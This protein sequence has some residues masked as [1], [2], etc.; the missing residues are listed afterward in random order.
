MEERSILGWR[1]GFPRNIG[2][3]CLEEDWPCF[4]FKKYESLIYDS[5]YLGI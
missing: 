2:L 4:Y 5:I 1:L 3:L